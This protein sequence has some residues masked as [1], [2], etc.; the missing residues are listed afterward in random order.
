MI[1]KHGIFATAAFVL[2]FGVA[3]GIKRPPPDFSA[4]APTAVVRGADGRRLWTIR[5]ARRADE[6]AVDAGGAAQ[7]PSGHAYELWL[8]APPRA[9]SLGLLPATRR[10]VIAEIPAVTTRLAGT[11]ML[12]VTLEPAHG[13]ERAVPSSP[14]VFRA[15]FPDNS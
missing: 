12:W 11:G 14:V 10:K 7:P 3:A 1:A 2:A 6:I 15:R 5:L 13:A 9:F 8:A 4:L